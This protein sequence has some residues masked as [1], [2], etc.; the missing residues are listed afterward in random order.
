MQSLISGKF[1]LFI[2]CFYHLMS[3]WWEKR[4]MEK[5]NWLLIVIVQMWHMSF[6]LTGY[7]SKLV[8]C[9]KCS[10]WGKA[11]KCRATHG[12]SVSSCLYHIWHTR[13]SD[14]NYFFVFWIKWGLD[15]SLHWNYIAWCIQHSHCKEIC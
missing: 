1:R 15:V 12:Y 9:P 13:R 10:W 3:L 11:G 6:L 8:I 2:L 7:P 14:H 4:R 5:G